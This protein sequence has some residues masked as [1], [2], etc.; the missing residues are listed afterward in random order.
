MLIKSKSHPFL[1]M[2]F[3]ASL[4]FCLTTFRFRGEALFSMACLS[5]QLVGT[6]TTIDLSTMHMT[7]LEWGCTLIDFSVSLKNSSQWLLERSRKMLHKK[8]H[9][10][11]M[12]VW[13]NRQSQPCI[14]KLAPQWLYSNHLPTFLRDALTWLAGSERRDRSCSS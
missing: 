7:L 13:I 2:L 5:S 8:W 12:E 14:E 11:E 3:D 9:S 1:L 4:L 10:N 6:Y